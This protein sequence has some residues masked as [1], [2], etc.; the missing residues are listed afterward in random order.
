MRTDNPAVPSYPWPCERDGINTREVAAN[1]DSLA[2]QRTIIEHK[3]SKTGR[4]YSDD[5]LGPANN[6]FGR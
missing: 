3:D 5:E 4:T 1:P 2:T 6:R